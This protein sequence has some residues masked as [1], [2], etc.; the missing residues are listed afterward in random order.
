MSTERENEARLR[1]WFEEVWN[2]KQP[3]LIAELFA[4]DSVAHGMGPNGTDL[5]GP[6]AFRKAYDLFTAAFSDL[7]VTVERTVASGD[8]VA[9]LLR[10]EVTHGGD[11]LG[12]PATGQRVNFP[13]MTMARFQDGKIVEGWN[14]LDL[15]AA[16]RQIGAAP[17][18][19]ALP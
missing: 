7:H 12:I 15:L 17:I 1:Y 4:P 9:C 5:R 13:V 10:C 2:K 8:T 11:H 19:E 3:Q 16:L 6:E 18:G 14:V